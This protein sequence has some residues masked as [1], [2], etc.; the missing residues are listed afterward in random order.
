MCRSRL[1][2]MSLR[3]M[4][5]CAN[6]QMC[7]C[8]S[9]EVWKCE[10]VKVCRCADAQACKW[11]D[12]YLVIPLRRDVAALHVLITGVRG[13]LHSEIIVTLFQK[14]CILDPHPLP[15]SFSFQPTVAM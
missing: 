6:V 12:W 4:C 9:V 2:G 14:F 1:G 11:V 10:S 7:K 8:E 5:K 13:K 3:S 15:L